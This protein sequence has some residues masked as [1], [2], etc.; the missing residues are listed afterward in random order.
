MEIK[1][2]A[3]V[4]IPTLNRYEHLKR[5]VESLAKCAYA[6]KTELI[7]GVDYPPCEKYIDGWKKICDYVPT[8]DGFKKVTVFYREKNY[9]PRPNNEELKK[10]AYEHYD[11]IIGTEDDNEFSPNF[12]VYMNKMLER[13][14]GDERIYCVCGYNQNVT[15][16]YFYKN[17]FY[18]T[19]RYIA[20]GIG[21]WKNKQLPEKYSS[22]DYLKGLI[23]NDDT[24]RTLKGRGSAF[25]EGLMDMLKIQKLHGDMQIA[26]YETL[27]YK[28]NICPTL[29]KV[30][31]HGNDGT[32]VHCPKNDAE[33][34]RFFEEQP[35]DEAMDF[36]FGDDIFVMQPDGIKI[37]SLPSSKYSIRRWVK[38]MI[39]RFDIFMLRNFHIVFHSKYI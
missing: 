10:Y 20:W 16:P 1:T 29:S 27:E 13:F 19:R 26:L 21:F 14:R 30:R 4:L 22:F 39:M 35:I 11:C 28:Y 24:Y 18:I 25:V 12:L 2:F 36:E 32:G 8:I 23:I 3:P 5:C 9:G 38:K 15:I 33:F 31:N 17:K 34:S 6:D 7:I 37:P